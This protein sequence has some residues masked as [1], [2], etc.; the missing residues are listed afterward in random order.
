MKTL[1]II[2]LTL[3]SV[4]GCQLPRTV[5]Q[6]VDGR[7]KVLIKDAPKGAILYVDGISMGQADTYNGDPTILLVEPGTHLVEVKTGDRLLV[8]Q[9]VFF[10]GAELRTITVPRGVSQ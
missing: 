8:S 5:V 9:R 7:S 2:A 4:T 1:L 3:V 10:G 6:T